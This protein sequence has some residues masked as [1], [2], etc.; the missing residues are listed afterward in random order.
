MC[1]CFFD[2]F[3][4]NVPA[5]ICFPRTSSQAQAFWY[6]SLSEEIQD[7][8]ARFLV[9]AD[10]ST[11]PETVIAF[12]KWNA[13]LPSDTV[14]PPLPDN[15]PRDGSPE[16][17][18]AF[19][20]KLAKKHEVIM[21]KRPHWYL[22]IIGTKKAYQGKGAGGM[23]IR[24]GTEKAD[25]DGVE[26]YLDASPMGAPIYERYGFKTLETINFFDEKYGYEHAFMVR[27]TRNEV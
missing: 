15:W 16:E 5:R 19:F 24:W 13:P 10:I 6:D 18:R 11:V 20:E 8:N 4:N 23:L 27:D 7:P 25:R 21:D 17:A 26:C 2:G 9:V 14:Y 1:E 22:E 3:S 12:A